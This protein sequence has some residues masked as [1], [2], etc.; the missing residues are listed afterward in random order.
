[1]GDLAARV[2]EHLTVPTVEKR[3]FGGISFMADDA[4]PRT[5]TGKNL[6]RKLKERLVREE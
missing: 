3:M 5:A 4:M 2:R 1:M 6:H